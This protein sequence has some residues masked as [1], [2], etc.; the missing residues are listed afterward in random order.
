ML[1]EQIKI[2]KEIYCVFFVKKSANALVLN[3]NK[4]VPICELF[5]KFVIKKISS[6]CFKHFNSL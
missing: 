5:P 1:I 6:K 4:I 2:Y 3:R